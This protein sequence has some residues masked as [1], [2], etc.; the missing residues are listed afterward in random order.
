MAPSDAKTCAFHFDKNIQ[1]EIV[2]P[3]LSQKFGKAY[4][5]YNFDSPSM[6]R[7]GNRIEL[8]FDPTRIVNGERL[9]DESGFVIVVDACTHK[10][11]DSYVATW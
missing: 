4:V 9:A 6:T 1:D 2:V 10:V 8:V 11:I 5:Y 7:H 3:V